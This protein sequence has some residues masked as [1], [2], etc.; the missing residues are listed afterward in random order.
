MKAKTKQKHRKGICRFIDEEFARVLDE[1][2]IKRL[3]SGK[4]NIKSLKADW[5][6]TLAITRHPSTQKIKEDII[7]ADLE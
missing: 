1:I 6:L 2:K 7:N 5:R 3:Q 4:D